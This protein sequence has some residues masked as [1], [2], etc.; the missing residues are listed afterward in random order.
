L[1]RKCVYE[2]ALK[3]SE[4]TAGGLLAP[5][6]LSKAD[7][8]LNCFNVEQATPDGWKPADFKPDT[9]AFR[10][11]APAYKL[12]KSYVKPATLADVGKS[13]ADLK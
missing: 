7:A 4:W 10:C 1:T 3:E 2:A 12:V 8:P 11:G 9:G 6:D 13:L 5:I